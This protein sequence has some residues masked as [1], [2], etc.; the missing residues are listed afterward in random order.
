VRA[1]AAAG[2]H[3]LISGEQVA[4]G[5]GPGDQRQRCRVEVDPALDELDEH[6]AQGTLAGWGGGGPPRVHLGQ[7]L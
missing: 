2:V 4:V 7:F 5:D 3:L 1:G 6:R